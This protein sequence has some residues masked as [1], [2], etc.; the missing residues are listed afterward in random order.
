MPWTPGLSFSVGEIPTAAKLNSLV[1]NINYLKDIA[2][3]EFTA[4]V[5]VTA[6]T[7]GTANSIV[8][9]GAITY[10]ATPIDIQFYS[11][12]LDAG[13]GTAHL[14]LVLFDASTV[15]GWMT[16]VPGATTTSPGFL[17]TRVTPTAGSHTYQV[18]AFLA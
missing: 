10:E 1:A 12:R 8:S 14:R 9:S 11:P 7:E 3:V 5:N 16:S 4:N 6:T 13:A 2:R 18:K 15:L 17:V